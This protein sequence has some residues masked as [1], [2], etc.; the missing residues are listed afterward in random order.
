MRRSV[1]VPGAEATVSLADDGRHAVA[2]R[3]IDEAGNAS[4]PASFS[5]R[6]DRTPPETVAF[7]AQ[8][9]A[10]PARVRAIVSDATSGVVSGGIE[11]R[12][13]GGAWRPLDT[14]L[15][16]GRLTA[17][18]DDAA[19]R[20]GPYELRAR[21]VDAAGNA[22]TG[23]AREDGAPAALTLP[24]R[25]PVMLSIARSGRLVTTRLLDG[26]TPL[27]DV[28]VR[29]RAA[30]ARAA[31]LAT[32]LRPAD[33]RDRDRRGRLLDPHR[34]RR[35]R[36]APAP[37]RPVPHGARAVRRRR[38]AAPRPRIRSTSARAP[39]IGLRA[40]PAVVPAGGAV[41]FRGSL[42][43]GP[44]PRG[45]KLVDLQARVDGRWR[46]FATVRTGRRGRLRHRHR[47]A[48]SSTGRTFWFRLLARKET[49]Y[50]YESAASPAVAVRVL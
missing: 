18:I 8:D 16:Q 22:A 40:V 35:P 47:F 31:G 6:I 45:G 13:A 42:L 28:P 2:Y 3:A 10:D 43:G 44:V 5:V 37:P 17:R 49:A 25:R 46:T 12:P 27:G 34:R 26:T 48:A 24:L 33:D 20:A 41:R 30:P 23:S 36:A 32:A 14:V 9:P 29:V 38:P 7:E 15:S 4:R 50:P 11:L 21:A 1:V 19:L 39:V